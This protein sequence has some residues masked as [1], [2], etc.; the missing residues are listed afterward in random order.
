MVA[1]R[2]IMACLCSFLEN[3]SLAEFTDRINNE[4]FPSASDQVEP[5]YTTVFRH[6][7]K[8]IQPLDYFSTE[9]MSYI[10][11]LT[12]LSTWPQLVRVGTLPRECLLHLLFSADHLSIV[13]PEKH[14]STFSSKS[15]RTFG[16][17]SV[18]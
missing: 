15:Q 17:W 4:F 5:L 14:I 9:L 16:R 12:R 7:Y 18:L 2:M 10:T 3:T 1:V 6:M 8:A 11:L 13:S